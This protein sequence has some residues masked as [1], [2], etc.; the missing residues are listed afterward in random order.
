MVS[1]EYCWAIIYI[2][3]SHRLDHT[4]NAST[5]CFITGKYWDGDPKPSIN[6][7]LP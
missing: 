5:P 4:K 2:V 7:S 6:V 1:A 3:R